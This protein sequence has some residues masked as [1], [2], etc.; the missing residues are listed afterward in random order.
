MSDQLA[1]KRGQ[2]GVEG[3]S[4][5]LEFQAA[6]SAMSAMHEA[7]VKV[8]HFISDGD[9]SVPDAVRG[10]YPLC[11]F[12]LCYNHALKNFRKM[13]GNFAKAGSLSARS[14]RE[15]LGGSASVR[16]PDDVRPERVAEAVV[17]FLAELGEK[18]SKATVAMVDPAEA[19]A[20]VVAP[21][22]GAAGAALDAAAAA[23][24]A[25]AAAGLDSS[26]VES[27]LDV[28]VAA[29]AAARYEELLYQLGAL[30]VS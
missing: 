9:S 12:Y 16:L 21:H 23:G 10:L 14:R 29:A 7:G 6:I 4:K 30:D 5:S 19:L 26:Q 24:P 2:G 17:S 22:A 15:N 13:I 25:A 11:S 1:Q 18:A 28:D 20:A 3:S 27:L 8:E